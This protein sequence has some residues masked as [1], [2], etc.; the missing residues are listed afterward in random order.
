MLLVK[1]AGFYTSL[2]DLGRFH[3]RHLGVPVSGAMDLIAAARVNSLLENDPND[4]VLEMTLNGPKLEFSEPAFI[5]FSGA[6]MQLELNGEAIELDQAYFVSAGSTLNCGHTS[7]GIRTYMA[8]KGGF[9]APAILGSRSYYFP[10]TPKK[11]IQA[12]TEIPYTPNSDYE[13]KV[14][15]VSHSKLYR[16]TTL[17]VFPGPEYELLSDA[18]LEALFAGTFTLAKEQDR[19]ACQLQE[20]IEGQ[21][22]QM[23]TSATLP[24]TVQLTPSGKL[25]ILMRDGQTTGGYP[26]I[27]QLEDYSV[28]VLAQK[29]FGDRLNFHRMPG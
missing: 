9:Q 19:M 29:K 14:L 2:Q 11:T 3:Y 10:V 21:S 7:H 27:L 17:N 6:E 25:I 24:G 23:I 22:H 15:R 4:A 12:F 26:R 18:Q 5:A 20:V 16:E 13:S 1:D 8:I 28:N